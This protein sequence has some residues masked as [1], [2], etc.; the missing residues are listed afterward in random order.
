MIRFDGVREGWHYNADSPIHSHLLEVTGS[1]AW[2]QPF[3]VPNP[4]CC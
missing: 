3:P 4:W 1:F 2:F